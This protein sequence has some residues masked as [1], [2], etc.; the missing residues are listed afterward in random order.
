[1]FVHLPLADEVAARLELG[2]GT[3]NSAITLTST[4]EGA[5]YILAGR[6]TAYGIEYGW[7]LPG[8]SEES[9]AAK[10]TERVNGRDPL[11]GLREEAPPAELSMPLRTDWFAVD[12]SSG[13]QGRAGSNLEQKV[14]LLGQLR[15]WLTLDS[16]PESG[17][18][19]W[20]MAFKRLRD[21][22]I[23][24]SG[25]LVHG[26]AY[27]LVLRADPKDLEQ[28][29]KQQNLYLIAV[30]AF[31][32]RTVLFPAAK[33]SVE[34]KYPQ[35][36]D[37][38]WPAEFEIVHPGKKSVFEIYCNPPKYPCGVDTYILLASETHI[39]DPTV[40]ESDAVRTRGPA[41]KG[42]SP[43]EQLLTRVG[44]ATRGP[45][46]PTPTNWSIQRLVLRSASRVPANP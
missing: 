42:A 8:E 13:S 32:A 10:V 14:L 7:I 16:P 21:G 40:L 36:V 39:P 4:P 2:G 41:V 19:P 20:R 29:I 27:S 44:H 6:L 45:R 3:R 5:H 33:S 30:D 12:E 43:L 28:P 26:E 23:I 17:G 31:G 35:P 22:A 37:G 25:T 38:A 24:T 15:A 18:F 9:K 1:L 34:T 11:Q 46:P